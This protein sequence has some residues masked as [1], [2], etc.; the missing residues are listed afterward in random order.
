MGL[1]TALTGAKPT[2]GFVCHSKDW[3]FRQLNRDDTL[4]PGQTVRSW[5]LRKVPFHAPAKSG[6][7]IDGNELMNVG[8]SE[9]DDTGSSAEVFLHDRGVRVLSVWPRPTSR[10]ALPRL[11]GSIS[12]DKIA[13]SRVTSDGC[14]LEKSPMWQA[15]PPAGR[16]Q[17]YEASSIGWEA[18]DRLWSG[19]SE[20]TLRLWDV[21]AGRSVPVSTV[22][23]LNDPTHMATL[24]SIQ[25]WPQAHLLAV[26]HQE[27]IAYVDTRAAQLISHQ[28]TKK[29]TE[30]LAL[31]ESGHPALFAGVGKSL[32]QYDVCLL[33]DGDRSAKGK[34]VGSW[35]L[36]DLVISINC[37]RS[38]DG[39]LLVAAG[40]KDGRAAS[41]DTA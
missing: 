14:G 32:L 21:A 1:V 15:A 18:E 19:D 13:V 3:L 36:S 11:V 22:A 39:A 2:G 12:T 4:N 30:C 34:V 35:D 5:D 41:L 17:T 8:Y 9:M 33:A 24:L 7:D 27:G 6:K 31:A 28:Y 16:W 25:F 40:C 26:A 38:A 10:E 37:A 23:V 29:A 20:S